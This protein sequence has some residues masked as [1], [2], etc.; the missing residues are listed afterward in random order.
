MK[1][2]A[3]V[4]Q[5]GGVGKTSVAVNLSAT[6][7]HYGQRVLLV[8][9]DPQGNATTGSGIDKNGSEKTLYGVLLEEYPAAEARATTEAGYDILIANRELAGAEIE[10]VLIDNREFRLKTALATIE[11][12]YDFAIIDCPPALN[13]LTVNALTAADAVIIPMQCEYYALEGLSD[14]VGTL[15]KVK[16]NLNPKIEI[17]ALVRT[18][19]D[20]RSALTIQVSDEIKNHFGDKVF[21]TVIPRNIRIAEAPS[22]GKPVILHDPSSKGALAHFAFA[23]ELLERHGIPIKQANKETTPS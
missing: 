20:P 17:E 8:D 5:K 14:L 4:N 10:M 19:Y 12:D 1:T 7:A 15:K 6:L 3:V 13:M 2:Y 11:P 23:R 22:Y 21:N 18:M 9:L 16:A